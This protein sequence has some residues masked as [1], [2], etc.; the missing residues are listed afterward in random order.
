MNDDQGRDEPEFRAPDPGLRERRREAGSCV[1]QYPL[2]PPPV[3]TVMTVPTAAARDGWPPGR[4]EARRLLTEELAGR[5]YAE[6]EP[7]PVLEWLAEVLAGF[8]S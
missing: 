4:D 5:E 6:A 7:N 8:R 3:P 1:V 2:T